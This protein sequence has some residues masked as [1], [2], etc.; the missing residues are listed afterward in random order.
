MN[1]PLALVLGG[2]GARGALQVG[3]LR[4]LLEAHIQPDLLVGTSIGAVNA[5]A[6]ATRGVAASSIALLVEDWRAATAADLLPSNALRLAMRA[7]LD[8]AARHPDHHLRDFF[9][10]HGL[11]P[12]LRFGD[13]RGVRLIVVATDLNTGRA[14]LYGQ[15]PR[16]SVLEGI[17]ASTA[18]PPWMPPLEKD[19]QWLMDG[20][21]VSNLPIEPAITAG[22]AEIIAL[23]LTDPRGM[24]TVTNGLGVFLDKLLTTVEQRQ[25]ELE[26]TSA[27]AH[28]V[29]VRRILLCDA[30]PVPLWDFSRTN[31]LIQQGY[32]IA[33]QAV[34]HWRPEHLLRRQMSL[35]ARLESKGYAASARESH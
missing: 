3:A 13:I 34:A 8:H 22:A 26:M 14:V 24:L 10:A 27:T 15:D 35:G 32:E 11:T 19:G 7:M 31:E 16:Q 29:P 18:L 2:G 12:D 6:L 25:V 33:R 5:A 30:T 20:G 21:V 4:A 9:V 28:G 23:D 1:R 17:L